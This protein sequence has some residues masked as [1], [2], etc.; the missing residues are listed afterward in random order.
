[1]AYLKEEIK[2]GVIIVSAFVILSGFVV[3]IGGSQLFEKLDCYTVRV[4]NAAGIEEGAQVKLGG[5]RIGRVMGVVPPGA[6]GEPITIRIGIKKGT[7]LY[8][9]TKASISQVGLMGDLYILLSIDT[10]AATAKERY[11]PGETI[12]VEEQVQMAMLM[13]RF[14]RISQSVE[15]VIKDI[16]TIFSEKNLAEIDSL[17]KNANTTLVSGSSN[18]DKVG[19]SLKSTT[20]KLDSVL[21]EVEGLV[22]DTRTEV[23]PLLKRAREGVE[24][25]GDTI[26]TIETTAKSA[27]RAINKQ[28][29][30]LENLLHTLNRTSEDLREVL[31]EFKSKPWSVIYKQEQGKEE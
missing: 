27:D 21:S 20:A 4:M 11:K 2:A 15:G 5:V 16:G 24:K 29:Q 28:S 1:V 31:H 23:P 30:N 17:L 19:A 18:L 10:I 13:A 7:V 9:G 26:R 3:L 8:K 14:D 6:P 22:K 25:A 12:Q